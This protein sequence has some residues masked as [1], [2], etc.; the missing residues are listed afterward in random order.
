MEINANNS[1]FV[2]AVNDAIEHREHLKRKEREES[3]QWAIRDSLNQLESRI[4]AGK[5]EKR[6]DGAL[7]TTLVFSEMMK[8]DQERLNAIRT[9]LHNRGFATDVDIYTLVRLTVTIP[10]PPPAGN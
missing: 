5:W 2:A 3:I 9:A 6:D 7:Q 8:F 4:Q 10:P 1:Q